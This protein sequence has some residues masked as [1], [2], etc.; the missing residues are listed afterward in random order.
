MVVASSRSPFASVRAALHSI[1][2]A[3]VASRSFF[4][5][6]ALISVITFSVMAFSEY[7]F[8]AT[9]QENAGPSFRPAPQVNSEITATDEHRPARNPSVF[10]CVLL[11]FSVASDRC[12]GGGLFGSH[13]PIGA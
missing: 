7:Q 5:N 8:L 9:V 4:T 10:C 1:I 11:C 12:R 6:A 13:L 3:P 2:P